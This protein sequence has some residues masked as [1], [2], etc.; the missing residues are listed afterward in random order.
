MSSTKQISSHE[1]I[2]A[3]RQLCH[4]CALQLSIHLL[5]SFWISALFP[6][7]LI[8][9]LLTRPCR[10]VVRVESSESAETRSSQQFAS[11]R[12]QVRSRDS[13]RSPFSPALRHILRYHVRDR[14]HA[15]MHESYHILGLLHRPMQPLRFNSIKRVERRRMRSTR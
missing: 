2:S 12:N 8:Y 13:K 9:R 15:T 7:H 14:F 3:R 11:T 4:T 1:H 10:R 5:D 6:L